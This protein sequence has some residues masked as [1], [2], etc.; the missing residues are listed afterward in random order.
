LIVG[1]VPHTFSLTSP[2]FQLCERI[3]STLDIRHAVVITSTTTTT[4]TAAATTTNHA[5]SLKLS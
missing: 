3:D 2:A 5:S 1:N 4:T